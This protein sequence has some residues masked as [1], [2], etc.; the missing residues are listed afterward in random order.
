MGLD[1][2]IRVEPIALTYDQCVELKLPRTPLKESELRAAKFEARYGS[3]ATELDAMAA[4]H[5]GKLEELVEAWI[6]SYRE[7]DLEDRITETES[8]AEDEIGPINDEVHE[9]H[10]DDIA[11]VEAAKTECNAAIEAAIEKFENI[12]KPV[13]KK[14]EDDLNDEA[15][16]ADDFDWP[17][18]DEYLGDD[19]AMFDSTR[20]FVEQTDRL[21][22]HQGKSIERRP[23]RARTGH[24]ATCANP[25]CDK[26]NREFISYKSNT[27]TCSDKCRSAVQRARNRGEAPPS[28]RGGGQKCKCK[29]CNKP[30][31][32][33]RRDATCCGK[34][35]C[36]QKR[37]TEQRRAKGGY[38]PRKKGGGH[39]R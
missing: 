5:P 20:D 21:K 19:D 29:Y 35:E 7:S 6:D 26:P 34:R 37:Q 24:K 8:K 17:E 32:S 2:D 38:G 36:Q 27:K 25:D 33:G 18:P 4:K 11:M 16:D 22:E 39:R 1:L 14:I 3:G 30:F 23:T 15:P 31:T 9:E 10:A 28:T 12:A 13:M